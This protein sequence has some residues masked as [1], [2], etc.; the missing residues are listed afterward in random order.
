MESCRSE[1]LK[2]DCNKKIDIN[3]KEYWEEIMQLTFLNDKSEYLSLT[4]L[5][6]EEEVYIEYNDQ[7]Y[8][9][10]SNVN[11]IRFRLDNS[12]FNAEV[13]SWN[14]VQ[15]VNVGYLGAW[16]LIGEGYPTVNETIAYNITIKNIT[17]RS[18]RNGIYSGY[19]T[20]GRIFYMKTILYSSG[21]HNFIG[22]MGSTYHSP[23][24][25][26]TG[27]RAYRVDIVQHWKPKKLRTN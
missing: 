16:S 21:D 14:S 9:L 19:T 6:Y 24:E 22:G 2:F 15:I 4:R 13:Y 7:I 26:S 3:P 20:D 11:N 27:C 10:Y 8:F 23:K 12:I 17:Y 5:S 18:E 1:P 25:L